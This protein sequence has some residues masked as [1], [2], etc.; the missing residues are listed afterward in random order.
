MD[1]R[2]LLLLLAVAGCRVPAKERA[3]ADA[4]AAAIIES[5]QKEA[6]GRQ[7]PFSI[8]R[9]S[10]TLRKRLLLAPAP[11]PGEAPQA[12]TLL[13]A[14]Q[15]GALNSREYQTSKEAVFLTALDL[16]TERNAFRGLYSGSAN[17][18]AT[19][20]LSSPT[21]P[22]GVTGGADLGAS[23][24]LKNGVL[25]AG[26]IG[27][28]VVR[29]LTGGRASA[30]GLFGDAS[31]SVPLLRGAG[32]RVVLEPLTQAE[33][34]VV[35]ALRDFDRFRRTF[36]VSVASGYLDVL[37]RFD[38]V[39]NAEENYRNLVVLSRRTDALDR[40]GR[41]SGI[42]VDQARQD[43]LRARDRWIGARQ[44]YEASLDR[45][46]TTLGLPPDAKLELDRGELER[47]TQQVRGS[48]GIAEEGGAGGE[49][50][51]ADAPVDLLAPGPEAGRDEARLIAL[52]LGRRQDLRVA[53]GRVEDAERAVLV[54]ADALRA[55]L[56]LTGSASAG[57]GRGLGSAES[58][59]GALRP[60][61][62]VYSAGLLLDLPLERTAERNAY[63]ESFVSLERAI[64]A[65]EAIEDAVRSGV[66][67]RLRTLVRAREGVR[68]QARAVGLARNR[69]DSTNLFLEAG[70]AQVRDVLEATEDLI[71]AQNALTGALVDY[72]VAELELQRDLDLLDVDEQGRWTEGE[73]GVDEAG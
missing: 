9:P 61:R 30:Y 49:V 51:A 11:P 52:A 24:L 41:I 2:L 3:K 64:R 14:L 4:A 35:Y 21:A 26:S 58:A 29:L 12:L 43:E 62:G 27:L 10:D 17:A 36:A 20:D 28:D 63:R 34:E 50:P 5:R 70:R 65:Q 73:V 57:E 69:V 47:T 18:E 72:R 42:E 22:D 48:F 39:R 46:K 44:E 68:I 54:A 33:R 31:V 37:R 19:A 6:L 23:R 16:D 55:G 67:D 32:R 15:V 53:R 38:S 71:S 60:S 13:D 25:L 45:F 66:R 59:D 7:E 8:E 56:T 1:A 40:A